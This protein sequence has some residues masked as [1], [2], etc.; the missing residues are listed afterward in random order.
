M[1][2]FGYFP[3]Y[4]L[5]NLYAAQLYEAA[6]RDLGDLD[7][8][9]AHGEFAPLREWLRAKIHRHGRRFLPAELVFRATGADPSAEPFLRY[10]RAKL[11]DIYGI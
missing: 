3:T 2:A 1:G 8:L 5:G 11:E 4:T 6:Q 7:G 10:L 9:I